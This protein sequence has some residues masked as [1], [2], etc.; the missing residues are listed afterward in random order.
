MVLRWFDI[1]YVGAR[2]FFG[3]DK[4]LINRVECKN[5]YVL[6]MYIKTPLVFIYF[7]HGKAE[8]LS[9]LLPC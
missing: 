7:N 9:D 4:L 2:L 1:K 5:G 3:Q 8:G 6:F